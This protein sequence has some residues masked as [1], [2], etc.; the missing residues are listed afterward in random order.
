MYMYPLILCYKSI[1]IIIIYKDFNVH[2]ISRNT[3]TSFS[4]L[5]VEAIAKAAE[6]CIIPVRLGVSKPFGASSVTNEYQPSRLPSSLRFAADRNSGM[7]SLSR[8]LHIRS[9]LPNSDIQTE[10]GTDT[11]GQVPMLPLIGLKFIPQLHGNGSKDGG[12]DSN[13]D[14]DDFGMDLSDSDMPISD[15]N[16]SFETPRGIYYGDYTC[17]V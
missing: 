9:A 3:I 16:E 13:G 11:F 17:I 15:H 12:D 8:Q 10:S 7:R 2:S 4:W 5:S 1:I 6:V 14:H